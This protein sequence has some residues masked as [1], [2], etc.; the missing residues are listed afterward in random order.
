M[1]A[2]ITTLKSS[3]SCADWTFFEARAHF[4]E[5]DVELHALISDLPDPVLPPPRPAFESLCRAIVGQQLSTKAAATIWHRVIVHHGGPPHAQ[6]C[7]ATSQDTHR[8]L[9]LSARKHEYICDLARHYLLDPKV[10]DDVGGWDDAS[11]VA[12]WTR[13]KGIGQWTV[14]MHLMFALHRRDVFAADDLGIRR[15]MERFLDV[16]RDASKATYEK[17]AQCWGPFRTAA[18]RFLWDALAAQPK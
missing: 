15:A 12:S 4:A 3:S 13:V 6:Q 5:A 7:V 14:Q 16:E 9:G 1:D 8:S 18:C 11:I 17:R 10:F 2:G